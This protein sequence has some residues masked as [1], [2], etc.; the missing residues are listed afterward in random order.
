MVLHPAGDSHQWS[1][2]G[3]ALFNIFIDDMDEGIESTISKFAGDTKLGACVDLLEGRRALQKDLDRLDRWA[4]SSNMKFNENKCQVPHFG[5]NNPM[6]CYRLGRS[7][8]TV[9]RRKGTWG[10]W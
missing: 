8:W 2:L 3:P 6:Q 5:H 4:E 10:Y 7:G 9:P 1:V